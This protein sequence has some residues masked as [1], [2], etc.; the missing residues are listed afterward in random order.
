MIPDRLTTLMEQQG[1]TESHPTGRVFHSQDFIETMF[2]LK[3][4]YVKRYQVTKDDK[5]VIELIYGPGHIFPLSQLYRILFN[6]A[7]NQSDLVYVY[8]AMSDIEILRI[9]DAKILAKLESEPRLY[10]DLFYEAGLRLKTN[11]D[12]LASNALA[13]ESKKVTHQLVCLADEFGQATDLLGKDSVQIQ[14]PLNST[15]I[16]EQLNISVDTTEDILNNLSKSNLIVIDGL[17]ITIPNRA[18]LKDTYL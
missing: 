5:H 15:D 16:A 7:I 9:N 14:V 2:M 8:Q 17:L 18:L 10:A 6:R 4:G 1:A 13:D 11:I 12:R 3:S